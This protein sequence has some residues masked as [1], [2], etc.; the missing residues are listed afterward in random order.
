MVRRTS[1]SQ[2]KKGEDP[3]NK[4]QSLDETFGIEKANVIRNKMSEKAYSPER[5]DHLRN[6]NNNKEVMSK[7]AESR[8][9]HDK[10]VIE[11][12]NSLRNDNI[13]TYIT[14]TYSSDP[15]PDLVLY[16]KD[17]IIAVEFESIRKW[18][19]SM[20]TIIK[21]KEANHFKGNF[22]D[23]V[24][25]LPFYEDQNIENIEENLKKELNKIG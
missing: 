22:F 1:L 4:G 18:K 14:T 5:V 21:K 11:C 6:L 23:L 20:S 17:K 7:R 19:P 13:R 16:Y 3:F 24:I 8:R 15:E 9:F 12:G 2:F 25:V 10:A